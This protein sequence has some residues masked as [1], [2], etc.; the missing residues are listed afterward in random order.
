MSSIS[1][2]TYITFLFEKAVYLLERRNHILMSE[3]CVFS[4]GTIL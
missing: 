1:R 3:I 4:K 2:D